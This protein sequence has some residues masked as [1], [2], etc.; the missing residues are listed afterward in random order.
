MKS[1]WWLLIF[2]PQVCRTQSKFQ[3][4]RPNIWK[5]YPISV[6]WYPLRPSSP[7]NLFGIQVIFHAM[8]SWASFSINFCLRL[9]GY[10]TVLPNDLKSSLFGS[11][12][13][14]VQEVSEDK[15]HINI[16][17]STS[18]VGFIDMFNS[19]IIWVSYLS[20]QFCC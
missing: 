2:A 11:Y 9:S 6:V 16:S 19:R 1:F 18:M 12:R 8:H 13:N 7:F 4:Q 14:F 10:L 3:V 20:R 17:R 5:C 15:S